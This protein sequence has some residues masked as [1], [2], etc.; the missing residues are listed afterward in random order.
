MDHQTSKRRDIPRTFPVLLTSWA[1]LTVLSLD[2]RIIRKLQLKR[3]TGALE[4]GG[5]STLLPIA[6]AIHNSS[7]TPFILVN[8]LVSQGSTIFGDAVSRQVRSLQ[9]PLVQTSCSD[10]RLDQRWVTKMLR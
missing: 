2:G 3:T 1:A 9:Y 8:P 7:L 4:A 6:I 5:L 10:L